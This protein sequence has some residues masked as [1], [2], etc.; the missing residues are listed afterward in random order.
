MTPRPASK[1]K[2]EFVWVGHH[3]PINVWGCVPV[4]GLRLGYGMRRAVYL[5][6]LPK[7]IR[8]MIA[9]LGRGR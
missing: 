9:K 8:T 6:T 2:P 1:K 3:G 4:I 5:D 7:E